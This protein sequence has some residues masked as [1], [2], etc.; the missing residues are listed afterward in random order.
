MSMDRPY[1]DVTAPGWEGWCFTSEGYLKDSAG[2]KYLPRDLAAAFFQRQ[3]WDSKAGHPG[4]LKYLKG[5]LKQLIAEVQAQARPSFVL[6]IE[7]ETPHGPE[8]VQ[9]VRLGG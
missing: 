4:E 5:Y 1:Q 9:S 7:R 8:L 3:S 6:R 2:N